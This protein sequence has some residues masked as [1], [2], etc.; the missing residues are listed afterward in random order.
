MKDYADCTTVSTSFE[1]ERCSLER[2]D[3]VAEVSLA[4]ESPLGCVD[5]AL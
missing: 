5:V 4:F 2:D 1:I 3:F